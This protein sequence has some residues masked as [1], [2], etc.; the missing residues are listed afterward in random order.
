MHPLSV[1]TPMEQYFFSDDVMKAH[2]FPDLSI[3]LGKVL[4]Q[5]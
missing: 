4:L 3:D 2:I 5:K 1:G